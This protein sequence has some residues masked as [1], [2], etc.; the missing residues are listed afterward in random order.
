[1]EFQL[2]DNMQ[3]TDARV[4]LEMDSWYMCKALWDKAGE[5]R[6]SD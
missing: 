3:K 6:H 4:I 5:K 2:L 1:M